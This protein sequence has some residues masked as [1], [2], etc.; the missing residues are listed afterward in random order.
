LGL[1][2]NETVNVFGDGRATILG[3]LA[4]AKVAGVEAANAGAEFVEPGVDSLASP[5]EDPLGLACRTAAIL[6]RHLGLE[7]PTTIAGE[8]LRSRLEAGNQVVREG[9]HGRLLRETSLLPQT[10]IPGEIIF[11]R[12]P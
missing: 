10:T 11:E 4:T 12:L 9:F 6:C 8:Q 2:F 1:G 5:A 3:F 7:T